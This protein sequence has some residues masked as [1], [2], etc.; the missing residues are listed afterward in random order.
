MPSSPTLIVRPQ[1]K[2]SLSKETLA[3]VRKVKGRLYDALPCD[4]NSEATIVL[5]DDEEIRELNRDYRGIDEPT[6]VLSFAYQEA[7]DG[8]VNPELLGDVVI[9]VP[10]AARYAE[11]LV[12]AEWLTGDGPPVQPWTLDLELAFL[13][14]HGFLHLLGYDHMEPEEEKEMRAVEREVFADLIAKRK[15]PRRAFE[16]EDTDAS[17]A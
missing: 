9:S 4:P 14:A 5:T 15:Q 16:D 11:S 6:D 8:D 3:W 1:I 12:H 10:T 2:A 13:L 7:V 17:D